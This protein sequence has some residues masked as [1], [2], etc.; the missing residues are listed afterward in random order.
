MIIN[1]WLESEK[2][3]QQQNWLYLFFVCLQ[4]TNGSLNFT[5]AQLSLMGAFVFHLGAAVEL[6]GDNPR[7]WHK[8][9]SWNI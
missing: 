1:N 8:T 7:R 4:G 9:Q 3:K 2:K 5:E 6:K